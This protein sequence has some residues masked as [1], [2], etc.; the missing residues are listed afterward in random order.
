MN[1]DFQQALKP[2]TWRPS[3]DVPRPICTIMARPVWLRLRSRQSSVEGLL[4]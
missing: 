4:R 3:A 2:E 1:E